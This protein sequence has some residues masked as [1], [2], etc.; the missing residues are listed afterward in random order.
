MSYI[1]QFCEKPSLAGESCLQVVTAWREKT[2][3]IDV[4]G[5]KRTSHG[6]EA[7]QVKKMC[8]RCRDA[9][10]KEKEKANKLYPTI[11][12]LVS[13]VVPLRQ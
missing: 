13:V 4:N 1:C 10:R 5:E 2:Y 7:E 11:S 3:E 9:A 8:P 12:G 6:K